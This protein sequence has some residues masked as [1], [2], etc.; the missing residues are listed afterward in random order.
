MKTLYEKPMIEF[1]A[2]ELDD[3]ITSSIE[4]PEVPITF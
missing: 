1:I 2:D 3:V 4:L